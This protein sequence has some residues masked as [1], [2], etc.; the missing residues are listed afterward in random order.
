MI[1]G[2][3]MSGLSGGFLIVP[4]VL[5]VASAVGKA[6][7]ARASQRG[8]NAAMN[9]AS[10]YD[11]RYR[12]NSYNYDQQSIYE[13]QRDAE[14]RRMNEEAQRREAEEQRRIYEEQRRQAQRNNAVSQSI[15]SVRNDMYAEMNAQAQLNN[16]AS[17]QML[18]ELQESRRRSAALAESDD[19]E[20]YRRYV[21]ELRTSG[22][23]LS[24][25][26]QN[27][28]DGFVKNYHT[29][30]GESMDRITKTV[31][32]QF[33]SQLKELQ[34]LSGDIKAKSEKAAKLAGEYIEE[35][36]DMIETL[37]RD[38]EGGRF[39]P[40]Q[41]SELRREL[42]EAAK[43]YDRENY[44]AALA[45]A[46]D[47]TISAAEEIFKADCK[48]QEWQNYH[49]MAIALSAELVEYIESQSV[50]TE[51]I[52][53]QVEEKTGKTIE[54]DVVGVKISD[55]T[56]KRP[57]GIT[58]YDYLLSKAK[59]I[60][61]F[62][63]SDESFELDTRQLKDYVTLINDKLY[64]S[65]AETVFKAILNM[66]N[67][68]SRQNISEEI[69]DFFEE[70]NFTFKGYSYDNEAHDDS[71]HI[72]LENEDT[73]EEI[74]VTLSPE[75]MQNGDVQTKVE[76]DQLMGD[77]AN[78]ERKEFY[79]RSIEEVVCDSTP[80][81]QIKLECNKAYKNKLSPNSQLRS[82]LHQ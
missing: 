34:Q 68:F 55:Y 67:A 73:G 45:A 60:N 74:I 63:E 12:N 28:Q 46:K 16:Q 1:G 31:N 11:Q 5:M 79:R 18:N 59:E 37:E 38:H 80:G 10:R 77:E 72:G 24:G 54:D 6:S 14:I 20:Q 76:I 43:Q 44:E 70:H 48:R 78:E 15:G 62:L 69:I 7:E 4:L 49:K 42:D 29:K 3:I 81:A 8:V 47:V 19:P 22:K 27:I 33:D 30:I 32:S 82:N 56:C 64:P 65:A 58:Q 66:S 52:K 51:E 41:L 61:A 71:L 26:M 9:S 75:L 21:S 17:Q 53:K 25:K 39:A 36:K 50:I 35:A 57:D 13:S 23:E 2:S 40:Q